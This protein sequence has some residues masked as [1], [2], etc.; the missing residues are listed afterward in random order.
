MLGIQD[1]ENCLSLFINKEVVK[2][3][4][5][6]F[7]STQDKFEMVHGVE[8]PTHPLFLNYLESHPEL[9]KAGADISNLEIITCNA[10][11]HVS[12]EGGNVAKY[13]WESPYCNDTPVNPSTIASFQKQ[14]DFFTNYFNE[15]TVELEEYCRCLEEEEEKLGRQ[16]EEEEEEEEDLEFNI[17]DIEGPFFEE[18]FYTRNLSIKTQEDYDLATEAD[19]RSLY[20]LKFA[21]LEDEELAKDDAV[22]QWL[23]NKFFDRNMRRCKDEIEQHGK[24]LCRTF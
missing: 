24:M 3:D 7:L 9:L 6:G 21:E 2:Y 19:Y 18:Y 11:G 15:E 8:C 16:E 10:I 5:M 17:D 1:L 13:A 4:L 23:Y 22:R 20:D 12:L 14:F